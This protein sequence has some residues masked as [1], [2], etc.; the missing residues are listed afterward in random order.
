MWLSRNTK[1]VDSFSPQKW[2]VKACYQV[3]QCSGLLT[4]SLVST[5]STNDVCTIQGKR[6]LDRTR[7]HAS[8]T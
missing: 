1:V 7:S 3:T 2:K 5:T 4:F 6:N 8:I